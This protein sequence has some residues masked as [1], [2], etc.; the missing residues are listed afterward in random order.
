M[1][2]EAWYTLGVV[3]L[4]L[5]AL[6]SNKLAVDLVLVA[7]V[8]LLVFTDT[9][10]G[11]GI[12]SVQ[13]A[14]FGM[15]NRGLA[16]IGFLFIVVR[17]LTETGAVRWLSDRVLGRPQS[18][19]IASI[20][21]CLPVTAMSG[22]MNNT[23]LVAMMIPALKDW[24][25]RR[26]LSPS[27][28]MI[29]LSY[30]AI[31]GGTCTLIGTSTN[32]IIH[33][34]WIES[35]RDPLNLFEIAK[36]GAPCAAI[37]LVYLIF[38]AP[39]LLPERGSAF[40]ATDDGRAYTIEML[41][42]PG[43]QLDGKTIE[44]AGL[45]NLAGLYLAEIE[46]GG[47]VLTAV[48]PEQPL[49]G[50]DRLV[51][52]GQLE[53]VV[54]LQ[55]I[56]GLIPATDQV[57][58]LDAPR[59]HRVMIEAVVSNTNPLVGRTVRQGQFRTVYNAVIIAVARN[60]ERIRKKIG[61]IVLK[62]GDTLLLEAPQRFI[63]QNRNSRDFFLVSAIEDAVPVR[64]EKAPLALAI[65]GLMVLI[66]TLQ[67]F[68]MTMLHAAVTAAG[69]MV[70]TRCCSATQARRSIDWQLIVVIAASLGL[71]AAIDKTGA[72]SGIGTAVVNLTGGQPWLVL[73]AVYLVTTILTETVTNNAAAVVMF[74]IAAAAAASIGADFAPF[75]FTIM[76]A[77]S[78][79]FSTPLG[80]QTNLMVMTP[81]GYHFSDYFRVGIPLNALMML[82]TVT[83]APMI[84]PMNIQ[85]G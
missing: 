61:D 53:S 39:R 8:T 30:A 31:L 4:T 9:L 5:G 57:V 2:W 23:P 51:F 37:G 18:P 41:L 76:M 49:M 65:L 44:Q 43:S 25:R 50:N 82:L 38:V 33:G 70:L 3:G 66:A 7:A 64:H 72:A 77:A 28:F 83:L 36:V 55:Q 35:G 6:A 12:L 45:R 54:D 22:F 21:L 11:G 75:L 14:L 1:N 29:P 60:G 84:W 67:P 10:A 34:M 80:Y 19:L 81:G 46:R 79:S 52:V 47:E 27:K 16:T 24:C 56:R 40:E 78:A 17:G 58:K 85:P 73:V 71:G 20:R 26:Q 48:G 68:G 32:L 13:D 62:P 74:P 15:S 69:L 63:E 42:S 59:P